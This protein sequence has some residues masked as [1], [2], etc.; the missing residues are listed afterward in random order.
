[1]VMAEGKKVLEDFVA[2]TMTLPEGLTA[3]IKPDNGVALKSSKGTL[4]RSFKSYR[5]KITL[6]GNKL[7]V[8]GSPNNKKTYVLVETAVAHIRNMAEGLLFGYRT[9]LKV[10]YSHFP[11]SVA[12]DK[13]KVVIKNFLGEKFPRKAKIVGKTKVE[14]KGQDITVTGMNKD[15][16]GQTSANMERMTR[17]RGK[18]IR[19]FQ[20]GIYLTEAGNIEKRTG[21]AIAITMGKEVQ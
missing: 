8:E 3:E 13:D 11:M 18:D 7:V 12:V 14:V 15:D 2:E 6:K 19:R 1:M 20:D 4:E 16:V 9:Q 5:V 10:V 21:P 17:V